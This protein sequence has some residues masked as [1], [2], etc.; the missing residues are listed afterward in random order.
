MTLLNYAS[1]YFNRVRLSYRHA[2]LNHSML[3]RL[4]E[5]NYVSLKNGTFNGFAQFSSFLQAL[6]TPYGYDDFSFLSLSVCDNGKTEYVEVDIPD[7][8]EVN[9][10]LKNVGAAYSASKCGYARIEGSSST[11][12]GICKNH[13]T[14]NGLYF[15]SSVGNDFRLL[16]IE[17]PTIIAALD[18]LNIWG[19][20]Y[21]ANGVST[22]WK[23][24]LNTG[25]S[26]SLQK[27]FK[28]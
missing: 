23:R 15:E 26:R 10:G 2:S 19:G 24:Y 3:F 25:V 8:L 18:Q 1:N 20:L 5:A 16:P 21:S 7:T 13:L 6:V 9:P 27:R 4:S 14:L 11:Q 28:G 22:R 12:E 17:V